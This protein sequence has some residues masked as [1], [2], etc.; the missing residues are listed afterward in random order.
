MDDVY[1][2][3][4]EQLRKLDVKIQVLLDR[5]LKDRR[6]IASHGNEVKNGFSIL[7][8]TGVEKFFN[9][10]ADPENSKN[11]KEICR[12]IYELP[13][14]YK[15][16]IADSLK[17]IGTGPGMLG[18][19]AGRGA[20]HPLL[21]P[22]A[23]KALRQGICLILNESE[24][25]REFRRFFALGKD[26]AAAAWK[27]KAGTHWTG[28]GIPKEPVRQ[29]ND[30]A[31]ALRD[32]IREQFTML[33][34]RFIALMNGRLRKYKAVTFDPD[35]APVGRV[36]SPKIRQS[37][38]ED[39][40]RSIA[41]A[42]QYQTGKTTISDV[43]DRLETND[44]EEMSKMASMIGYAIDMYYEAAPLMT[45]EINEQSGEIA[46]IHI[47]KPDVPVKH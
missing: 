37:I 34:A 19:W 22:E 27:A 20:P 43:V 44:F 30:E 38:I 31:I 46:H 16:L 2:R 39:N 6:G 33:D 25:D 47:P 32:K 23:L 13:G 35:L 42:R 41:E 7:M 3:D 12:A 11:F 45:L 14:E 26:F 4:V 28:V 29:Y 18:S 15:I 9:V 21:K 1:K 17:L 24:K 40:N 10:K 5:F 36:N 8:E